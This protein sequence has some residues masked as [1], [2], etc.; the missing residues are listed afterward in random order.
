MNALHL[1]TCLR[2]SLGLYDR[3]SHTCNVTLVCLVNDLK[4]LLH[5][6]ISFLN[7]LVSSYLQIFVGL[8]FIPV[9]FTGL[10]LS[11]LILLSGFLSFTFTL[12]LTA[13]Y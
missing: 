6:L 2:G 3:F 11:V 5:H 9:H 8:F 12:E 1:L 7:T 4:R 10:F 13:D